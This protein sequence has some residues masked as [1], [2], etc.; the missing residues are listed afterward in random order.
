MIH[1]KSLSSWRKNSSSDLG[2]GILSHNPVLSV[3]P[4]RAPLDPPHGAGEGGGR[5][6][7]AAEMAHSAWGPPCMGHAEGLRSMGLVL[8]KDVEGKLQG[9]WTLPP[10]TPRSFNA[11]SSHFSDGEV[12][13]QRGLVTCAK[14]HSKLLGFKSRT[15]FPEAHYILNK[16]ICC[17][18]N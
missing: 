10:S 18:N 12:E 7:H 2:S 5:R 6:Q 1:L 9:P 11:P 16:P 13:T 14:S 17:P 8:Q 4:V 15:P 3:I